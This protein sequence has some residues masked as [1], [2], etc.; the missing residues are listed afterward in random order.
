M[1]KDQRREVCHGEGGRI[2]N[3]NKKAIY[4]VSPQGLGP[5]GLV[6]EMG[7]DDMLLWMVKN[8]KCILLFWSDRPTEARFSFVLDLYY[9]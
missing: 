5:L 6:S 1:P 7:S 2:S 9:I 8:Q 4:Q 3:N